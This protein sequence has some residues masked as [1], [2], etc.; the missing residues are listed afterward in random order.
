MQ[1]ILLFLYDDM[2]D[3]EMTF[4]SHLFSMIEDVELITIAYEKNL[5]TGRSKIQYMPHLTVSQ[6]LELENICG[7]IIPGGWNGEIRPE[8]LTLIQKLHSEEKL[9]GAICAAPRFLAHAGILDKVQYTTSLGEWNEDFI[10]VYGDPQDPFPRSTF[11]K[12]PL[13]RDSNVITA[14]GNAFILF[15]TEICHWFQAFEDEE[16]KTSF[17]NY[18]LCKD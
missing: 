4:A 16:D 12:A 11:I 2:A 7:L 18:Y 1:K 5:I 14:Q 6:S 10:K 13:V 3:F 15:A 17:L 9:I 8:I